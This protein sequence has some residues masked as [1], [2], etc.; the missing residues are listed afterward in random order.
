MRIN[1]LIEDQKILKEGIKMK[2]TIR[3]LII[4]VVASFFL[5]GLAHSQPIWEDDF[6]S[7]PCG[8]WPSPWVPDG[9]ATDISNNF[10][11]CTV[12][13]QGEKSLRLYG[14]V[15]GCWAA[16]TYR[17]LT[18]APP[19]QIEVAVRNGDEA[20]SGC[21]PHRAEIILRKGFDWPNPNRY[22][23]L[24]RGDGT[25]QNG[26]GNS[27]GAYTPLT[28]YNIGIRYERPS[29]SE[30]KISYWIDGVYKGYEILPPLAEEDDLTNLD[31]SSQEGSAWFDDVK[32]VG[33]SAPIPTLTEWGLIIFGVV[34]VGF[35]TY[36]FLKRRKAVVSVQ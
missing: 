30:V 13:Y 21:H 19:Y 5:A 24:F 7:Y 8:S 11:D 23:I 26:G 3:L 6:E 17:P 25:I 22:L 34:L 9:N 32:V 14:V 15:N 10:V 4:T 16:I 12:S 2:S 1:L 27:L 35:I 28:W 18:V 36:V 20:L 33:E 29:P 31:L